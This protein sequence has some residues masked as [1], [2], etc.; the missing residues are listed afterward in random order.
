MILAAPDANHSV[1][2]HGYPQSERAL[3]R[4]SE[5][6]AFQIQSHGWLSANLPKVE[7][8]PKTRSTKFTHFVSMVRPTFHAMSVGVAV[9]SSD[10]NE[11]SEGREPAANLAR[12]NPDRIAEAEIWPAR[13]PAP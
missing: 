13:V 1:K 8:V 11:L 12:H 7:G 4:H 2:A 10:A 3:T 6:E 5:A 9:M